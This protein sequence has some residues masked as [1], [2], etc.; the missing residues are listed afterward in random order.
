MAEAPDGAPRVRGA[1][2]RPWLRWHEERF[3]HE[4]L[5]SALSTLPR[6]CQQAFAPEQPVLGVTNTRW[7]PA[8][9]YHAL[10]DALVANRSFAELDPLVDEAVAATMDVLGERELK[11]FFARINSLDRYT[12]LVNALW[13]AT[14]DTGTARVVRT[15]PNSFDTVVSDWVDHHAGTCDFFMRMQRVLFARI[16]LPEGRVTRVACV[17]RGDLDCRSRAVFSGP[18]G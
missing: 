9:A 6:D 11:E 8:R 16:G 3:G 4:S 7:Y 1:G 13:H 14:Y 12:R 10:V 17:A 2:I 18:V 15:G 5:V